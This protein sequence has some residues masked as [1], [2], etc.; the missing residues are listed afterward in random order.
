MPNHCYQ[1]VEVYG[2]RFLVKELYDSSN[3][4]E[5]PEFCQLDCADAV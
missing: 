5:D 3:Q 4:N 1:S 2:P